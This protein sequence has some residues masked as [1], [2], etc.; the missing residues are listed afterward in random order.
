MGNTSQATPARP[1][2]VII[3]TDLSFDDYVA[4]LFLLR[5]P[6]VDVRAIT[7][8]NGVVHVKPGIENVRRLLSHMGHTTVPFAGG[9]EGPLMGQH[10]FPAYW[11]FLLDYAPRFVVSGQSS[12]IPSEPSAAELICQQASASKVPATFI[13]LG[14]LTNLAL[15]LRADPSLATRLDRVCISGGALRADGPIRKD[16]HSYPNGFAEWNLYIDPHAA[17]VVFNSGVRLD[18]VPLDVTHTSGSQPLLFGRDFVRRL[19]DLA[20]GRT[21]KTMVRI[22]RLWQFVNP[23]LQAIPVWD[24]VVAAIAVDATIGRDWRNL[25]IRVALEPED[26]AGQT[27]IDEDEQPNARVC[28]AGSQVAFEQAYLTTIR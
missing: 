13:A 18:L 19:S 22:L 11:R 16:V 17:D 25:A 2:P 28:L 21:A 27:I 23:R 7:V 15:A 6:D 1:R 20:R 10:A 24:A 4:L 3:D 26:R 5:H 12:S 8:V 14:P 9:L